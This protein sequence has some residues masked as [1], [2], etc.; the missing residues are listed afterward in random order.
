[1]MARGLPAPPPPLPAASASCQLAVALRGA[2]AR[3]V[4][5]GGRG[6]LKGVAP[7][8]TASSAFFRETAG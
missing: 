6:C 2:A 1:M 8:L 4:K 7:K 3:P 5:P